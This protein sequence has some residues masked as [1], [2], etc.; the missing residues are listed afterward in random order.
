M[1]KISTMLKAVIVPKRAFFWDTLFI[2][3]IKLFAHLYVDNDM[4]I[5]LY[6]ALAGQTAGL[7]G[8]TFSFQ[9]VIY[10]IISSFN[11]ELV[12]KL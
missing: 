6:L 5:L 10:I 1:K 7:N 12:I 9:L 2:Y 8:M 11:N 3:I 4:P